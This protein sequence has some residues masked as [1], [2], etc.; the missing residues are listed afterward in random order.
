MCNNTENVVHVV[1]ELMQTTSGFRAAIIYFTTSSL[2]L[3]RFMC[4]SLIKMY[5][6]SMLIMTHKI[7]Q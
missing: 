3:L 7:I 6:M 5:L 2:Q 1:V 4:V